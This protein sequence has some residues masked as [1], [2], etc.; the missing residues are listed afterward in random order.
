MINN[1]KY[2]I[3]NKNANDMRKEADE[4]H[5]TPNCISLNYKNFRKNFSSY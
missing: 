2:D 4:N 5:I 3:T 1:M